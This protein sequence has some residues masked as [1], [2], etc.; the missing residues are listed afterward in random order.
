VVTAITV[1][2]TLGVEGFQALDAEWV[3][4]QARCLLAACGPEAPK[5]K[6]S[7]VTGTTYGSDFGLTDHTGRERTLADYG[8]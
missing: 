2:D 6:A 7:D 5:F 1:Q 3:A 8:G 4:D